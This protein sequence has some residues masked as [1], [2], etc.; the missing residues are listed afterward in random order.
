MI[1]DAMWQKV[2]GS[3]R[4]TIVRIDVGIPFG[5]EFLESLLSRARTPDSMSAEY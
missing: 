5:L 2:G 4:F 1:S 3:A